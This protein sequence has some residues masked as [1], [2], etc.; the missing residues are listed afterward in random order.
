[1]KVLHIVESFGGGVLTSVT[2]ICN[3]LAQ[4][5]MQV[6]LAYSLRPETP[7]NFQS[8]LDPRVYLHQ[9][10]LTRNIDIINDFNSVFSIVQLVRQVEPDILHL[11][12]SKAGFLGRL[13]V[14]LC[15]PIEKNK[16]KV[17]YSP[18]GFS[19]LQQDANI[20]KRKAYL[21]LERLADRFGG[22]II[23]CSQSEGEEARYILKARQVKVI[24]NAIDIS[25]IPLALLTENPIQIGI[26]GR[27]APQRNPEMFMRLAK[28]FDEENV[29]FIWVGGGKAD[30]EAILAASGIEVTGWLSRD[31][32]LNKMAALNIYLHTSLWEG[33]PLSL[34]EAMTAGLPAVVTDVIGNRDVVEHS[35]TG[36]I[37]KNEE[38]IASYLK[39]LIKNK[40]LR[41]EM[42]KA[43]RE[44]ALRRFSL[45]RL[46]KDI[47]ELYGRH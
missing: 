34:I 2:Q 4:E 5:G 13:A 36:F 26:S 16:I 1:M 39:I 19:F 7:G 42:G 43:A 25:K 40:D 47:L 20:C 3:I 33:M 23:A 46:R 10:N 11:H 15:S 22:T 8:L 28:K 37:G 9:L 14:C 27:I 17:F 30:D 29:K 38:D 6:H 31:V 18:R 24:D 21:Y 44:D 12:S 45:P 32:A 35:V 41:L